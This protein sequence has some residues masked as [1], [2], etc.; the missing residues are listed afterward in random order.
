MFGCSFGSLPGST[1]TMSLI[2]AVRS[3]LNDVPLM[4]T[5]MRCVVVV[6][7]LLPCSMMVDTRASLL[8]CGAGTFPTFESQTWVLSL[9]A[10][11]LPYTPQQGRVVPVPR[12]YHFRLESK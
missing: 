3:G 9:A 6:C 7:L 2:D 4:L 1:I 11:F 10:P 5:T 8:C 12:R